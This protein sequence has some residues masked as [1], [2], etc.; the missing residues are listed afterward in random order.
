V[1]AHGGRKVQPHIVIERSREWTIIVT[2]VVGVTRT[3]SR[4]SRALMAPGDS[5][6]PALITIG[7]MD[8]IK[9]RRI[10]TPGII[11]VVTDIPRGVKGLRGIREE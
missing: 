9:R 11:G 8:T 5:D 4:E 7:T 10:E 2:G 3:L 1:Q 6:S